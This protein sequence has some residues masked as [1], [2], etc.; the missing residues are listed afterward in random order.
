MADPT[1]PKRR[2]LIVEDETMVS[3]LLEDMLTERGYQPLGPAARLEDALKMAEEEPLDAAL[4]DIN[5]NGHQ[6]YPVA[7]VMAR[8]GIPFIFVTG[9]GDDGIVE[10]YRHRPVLQ[11]PFRRDD[12]GRALSR[13]IADASKT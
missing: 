4:L 9:Y 10:Q 13:A 6:I 11:K 2:I 5:L 12:L 1:G 7:D 3:M 8:R